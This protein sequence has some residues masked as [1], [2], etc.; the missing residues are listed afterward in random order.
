MSKDRVQELQK[1][2]DD[3]NTA[4][5]WAAGILISVSLSLHAWSYK[6]YSSLA[7]E[8]IDKAEFKRHTER[9][10][11]RRDKLT[12]KLTVM[13]RKLARIEAA[14]DFIKSQYSNSK[15]GR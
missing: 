11:N 12:D 9:V 8:K 14:L 6:A 1:R 7:V 4:L 10:E 3:L 5:R 2:L 13:E 15:K